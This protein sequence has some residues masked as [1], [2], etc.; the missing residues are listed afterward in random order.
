MNQV[1]CQECSRNLSAKEAY[2]LNEKVLCGSCAKAAVDRAKAGGQPA[3]VTRYVDKSI[4]ARCN[5]YIGEGGGVAAGPVRLCLPCSELVQ[6]W[7]Y[8]QWLK[9][10]LIGLLLL[11]VFALF[12]GRNYF[13]A[14]KDLYR[15]E[16]L[17]EQGE[18]QKALPYLREALKIAPNSDKGALLTA[19]T[20]LLIGDVETAAKA[21]MGHEGGRFENADK[22]EFREVDD[23]WK[24]ANSALEQLGKAAKLEEQDGNEVAAAKLAHGAAALYPQLLHVD[25]VVDEY[26]EGVA[27]VNKDYDTYLSL[28]EKDW[29]L[30]PTGGTASMLSSALACK[31]AVSGVVSYRQRSEEML[32]KAKE[33]SQGNKESLDRLAEF[34][35][36]NHYRLESREIINK[37]EYDRRF[38]GGKNSAK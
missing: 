33:L 13:Q 6:N 22:P 14:G 31:Y 10:S 30:W 19:K 5:T 9:L 24:K 8:P 3:Q 17:V 20:A 37:T 23:L 15:G 34:E 21:L 38:R 25:I 28:A 7:P 36:R 18:Y 11:L 4:C 1:V 12:H 32:S 26:D 29:K 35:E 2:E 27:F 16:Q